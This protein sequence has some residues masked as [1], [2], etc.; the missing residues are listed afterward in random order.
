[1]IFERS[2]VIPPNP[3]YGDYVDE[4]INYLSSSDPK[5]LDF[6][7]KCRTRFYSHYNAIYQKIYYL[8]NTKRSEINEKISTPSPAKLGLTG[9]VDTLFESASSAEDQVSPFVNQVTPPNDKTLNQ[10]TPVNVEAQLADVDVQKFLAVNQ[11]PRNDESFGS[12]NPIP[13]TH[14]TKFEDLLQ[15]MRQ[16]RLRLQGY[17]T[18]VKE[19]KKTFARIQ[20]QLQKLVTN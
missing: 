12:P 3:K 11:Q 13:V 20:Q 19:E 18:L 16:S 5:W 10:L 7:R 4:V 17:E 14:E 9:Q 2:E 1:M 8:F 15:E 6:P